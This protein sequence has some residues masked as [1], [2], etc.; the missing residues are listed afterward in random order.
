M[1]KESD[2]VDSDEI[3]SDEEYFFHL[4]EGCRPL[5]GTI[6]Y[7]GVFKVI[8]K[9]LKVWALWCYVGF[10]RELQYR[11]PTTLSEDQ[12]PNIEIVLE[13][14]AWEGAEKVG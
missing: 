12:I 8:G 4:K 7:M 14:T 2:E 3:E 6:T 5:E 9:T 10:N 13:K 11:W 1:S